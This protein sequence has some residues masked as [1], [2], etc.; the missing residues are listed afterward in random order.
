MDVVKKQEEQVKVDESKL[1]ALTS[2]TTKQ[3]SPQPVPQPKPE[4]EVDLKKANEKLTDLINKTEIT[5]F[6]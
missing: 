6:H 3:E 5:L 4:P 1:A 2:A